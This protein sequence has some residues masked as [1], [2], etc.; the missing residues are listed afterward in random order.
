MSEE[1]KSLFSHT[2]ARAFFHANC[3]VID[4]GTHTVKLLS[5]YEFADYCQKLNHEFE[6]MKS[7]T[8]EMSKDNKNLRE[9]VVRLE[10]EVEELNNL[11]NY[12]EEL[13]KSI[14]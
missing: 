12:W 7:Y 10:K 14:T 2:T 8:L 5:E 11:S 6:K 4:T 13:Y 3:E 9:E 1:N